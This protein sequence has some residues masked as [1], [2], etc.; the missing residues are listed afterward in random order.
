MLIWISSIFAHLRISYTFFF[1][2]FQ[3]LCCSIFVQNFFEVI[4]LIF[5]PSYRYF[6]YLRSILWNILLFLHFLW[7]KVILMNILL[8][9]YLILW[10]RLF[11]KLLI[12][13]AFL[14]RNLF[15]LFDFFFLYNFDR[16]IF[17][18]QYVGVILVILTYKP[19]YFFLPIYIFVYIALL[20]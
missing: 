15:L 10:L 4:L 12:L 1:V 18:N 17:F 3:N 9:L 2:H 20:V 6:L 13:C 11:Q 16:L 5:I 7:L 14:R 19:S 8:V